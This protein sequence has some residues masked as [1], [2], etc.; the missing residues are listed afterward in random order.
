MTKSN[1]TNQ[2]DHESSNE[3]FHQ[4]WASR[5]L[6]EHGKLLSSD[7]KIR[8][9]IARSNARLVSFVIQKF[10]KK[11]LEVREDLFQEG[12]TGLLQAIDNFD[13]TKGFKF[14]SYATKWILQACFSF[15]RDNKRSLHVPLYVRTQQNKVMRDLM[16]SGHKDLSKSVETVGLNNKAVDRISSALK[17]Q[18]IVGLHDMVP[19][20]NCTIAQLLVS[21][22]SDS[23]PLEQ[24]SN[25]ELTKIAKSTLSQLTDKERLIV[26]LRFNTK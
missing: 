25:K 9:R 13:P 6:D 7:Q 20:T 22:D 12:C 10:L 11:H 2:D 16:S 1:N 15:I 17:S 14:S 3:L 8:D 4:L 24:M 19:G 21:D 18:W 23:S 5:I 26:L